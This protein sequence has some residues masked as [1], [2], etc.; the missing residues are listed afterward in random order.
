MEPGQ[1]S[2]DHSHAECL[3]HAEDSGTNLFMVIIQEKMMK[4]ATD[5]E[6][7]F[8]GNMPQTHFCLESPQ[9]V[10]V[11]ESDKITCETLPL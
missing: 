3:V 2:H 11:S 6:N 9:Y 4:A 5:S 1:Y 10:G 8:S 7:T